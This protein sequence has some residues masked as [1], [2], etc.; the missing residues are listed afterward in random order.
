VG[1]AGRDQQDSKETPWAFSDV[2]AH[3]PELQVPVEI[4]ALTAGALSMNSQLSP[5]GLR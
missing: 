3:T 2:T 5:E 1:G 4:A